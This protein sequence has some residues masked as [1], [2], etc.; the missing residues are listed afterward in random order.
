MPAR[1]SLV[2]PLMHERGITLESLALWTKQSLSQRYEVIVV[3][4]KKTCIPPE[5]PALLRPH[6]QII[7]GDFPEL[8]HHYDAGIR[9][10]SGDFLFIT[11]SHCLPKRDCLEAMERFL[12][13]HPQLAGA[14]T[15]S[16][17]AYA[18]PYEELDA[19]ISI[20]GFRA[21]AQSD[22]WRKLIVHGFA[23]R[24]SIYFDLGGLQYRY[25]RFAEVLFSATLRDAGHKLGFARMAT[26]THRYRDSLQEL[27]DGTDDYIRGEGIYRKEN[28]G[29]DRVGHTY[30]PDISNPYSP[31]VKSLDREVAKTLFS[32]A[33]GWNWTA[34]TEAFRAA[35]RVLAG[36]LGRRG[37][38]ASAWLSVARGRVQCWKHRHD[39]ERLAQPYHELIPKIQR[40][41]RVRQLANQPEAD[42][43]LPAATRFLSIE[44]LPAWSL[45]GFHSLESVK[46]TPFRWTGRIAAMRIPITAGDYRLRLITNGIRQEPVPLNL[47]IAI[48]GTRI[49]PVE[50]GDGVYELHLKHSHCQPKVQTLVLM[51]NPICPWKQGSMD[52]RELGL[53][54]FGIETE[55]ASEASPAPHPVQASLH[56]LRRGSGIPIRAS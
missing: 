6:D 9:A 29:P 39:V 1:F 16:I 36:Q 15:D 5:L 44:R 40:L 19:Q 12:I 11:E 22:D 46:R 51:C 17:P 52:H 50:S 4:D 32:G 27:I 38:V 30:F 54:I 53:P 34:M 24:R 20:V 56:L 48:N 13:A 41:S 35:G 3:A 37:P 47:Q 7:R 55:Q 31:G 23:L 42:L 8:P 2:F 49:T 21:L 18:S 10:G 14:C 26:V 25:G 43:P 45:Y 33:F 28:P